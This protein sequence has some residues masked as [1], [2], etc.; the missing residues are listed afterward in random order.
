MGERNHQAYNIQAYTKSQCLLHC[1]HGVVP[2]TWSKECKHKIRLQVTAHVLA[3]VAGLWYI[4]KAHSKDEA[5]THQ[6]VSWEALWLRWVKYLLQPCGLLL[7]LV[8]RQWGEQ[9]EGA[10]PLRVP[11]LWK[12]W[13]SPLQARSQSARCWWVLL[14]LVSGKVSTEGNGAVSS[15]LWPAQSCCWG[16]GKGSPWALK[17]SLGLLQAL[18]DVWEQSPLQGIPHCCRLAW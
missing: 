17:V 18:G 1:P 16:K 9:E 7:S 8:W 10:A 3:G 13:A 12:L 4:D 15:C 6:R 11:Y 2:L 5:Q 14:A